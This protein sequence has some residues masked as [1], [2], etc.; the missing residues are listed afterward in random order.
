MSG[1]I[2][3]VVAGR[4][5]LEEVIGRG[6]HSVVFRAHDR[7]A[8]RVVAVKMLHDGVAGNPEYTVRM[9]REQRA[10]HALSGTAAVRVLGLHT[11]ADGAMCLIM[12]LLQGQD[13][14][15][16]LPR[17]E[18]RGERMSVAE[19]LR[20][21]SPIVDTLESAHEAGIVHRDLKPGNIYL[22][23]SGQ[24]GGVR[25]LDFGLAKLMEAAPLT[26]RGMIMGSPSYIAP[27]VWRGEPDR[28][29]HRVDVYS[30][31]AI[32]FRALGGR[33]PFEGASVREK[34]ELATTAPRPS[35]RALRPELP[36]D[37]DSWVGQV[38]AIDPGTRF[39][40]IRAMWNALLDVL[41]ELGQAQ[42]HVAA[43]SAG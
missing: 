39:W 17:L 12:E 25:L 23:D 40:R 8:D 37:I 16:Y 31:G 41:G 7:Q 36:S 42:G 21:L 18:A 43:S 19:L 27:E 13:L 1:L 32:V 14:D 34:L 4:Y 9:V 24:G 30:L 5:E 38:L 11:S 6:G 29:D 33:V 26:R 10:T 3:E 2:G 22:I 28:L 35:L 15:D 20:V